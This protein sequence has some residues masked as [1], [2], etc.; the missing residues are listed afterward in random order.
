MSGRA[1]GPGRH[2]QGRVCPGGRG[3]GRARPASRALWVAAAG[4]SAIGMGLHWTTWP[5][6]AEVA[7]AAMAAILLARWRI[8][9]LL[10]VATI[11]LQARI[12]VHAWTWGAAD[13]DVFSFIQNAAGALLHGQDPYGPTFPAFVERVGVLPIH[14]PY[15][16]SVAAVAAPGRALGDVRVGGL[17]CTLT[18]LS[19]RV[20]SMR[21]AVGQNGDRVRLAALAAAVGITTVVVI[22]AWVEVY[23]MGLFAL[24]LL[25]RRRARLLGVVALALCLLTKPTVAPALVPVLLWSRSARIELVWAAALAVAGA[26][27]FAAWAGWH[28]FYED[29][30]GVHLHLF[31]T[32]TDALTV[33][34]LLHSIG[35]PFLGTAAVALIVAAAVLLV[36]VR[37][38]RDAGDIFS[39]GALLT[40]AVLV[41]AK[42]AFMNYYWAAAVLM[43]LA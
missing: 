14:L 19:A 22:H 11:G 33:D 1:L 43:L 29:V 40:V 38:P 4:A 41:C 16:P 31:P 35:R 17:A 21:C 32:R 28:S 2:T 5:R 12:L 36:L 3:A 24:W 39:A 18:A 37:R 20:L 13:L 42:E 6:A 7:A 15:G 8:A 30:V 9:W 25:L 23:T 34:A 26:V 10:V 27:P